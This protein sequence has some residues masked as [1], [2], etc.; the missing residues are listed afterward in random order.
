MTLAFFIVLLAGFLAGF[1]T[2]RHIGQQK[3]IL[4]GK[5]SGVIELRQRSYEQGECL[6]C[7]EERAKNLSASRTC[8]LQDS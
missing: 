6:L 3:G 8:D 7:Q 2:G 1:L 4:E 5:V